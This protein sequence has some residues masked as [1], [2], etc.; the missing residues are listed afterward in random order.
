[1]TPPA[2]TTL[3]Q[4]IHDTLAGEIGGCDRCDVALLNGSRDAFLNV[5]SWTKADG[6]PEPLIGGDAYTHDFNWGGRQLMRGELVH[7][8]DVSVL[9]REAVGERA[10]C[11]R[12]GMVSYVA[13]PVISESGF[14]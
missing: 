6:E 2:A 14:E 5:H 7:V 3:W 10:G 4:G 8:P 12:L 13:I 11:K 1:M 9:P